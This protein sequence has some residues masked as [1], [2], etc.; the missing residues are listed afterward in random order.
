MVRYRPNPLGRGGF[1]AYSSLLVGH[2]E[3]DSL[4]VPISASTFQRNPF[5]RRWVQRPVVGGQPRTL[6]LGGYPLVPL[7]E[8]R[9]KAFANRRLARSGGDPLAEKKKSKAIPTF[10][11]A[12][13]RTI[14][15][16]R[17]DWKNARREA[18]WWH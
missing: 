7:A 4:P 6:G 17:A 3:R 12:A 13:A 18:Q 16:H 11:D 8:A 1:G 10:Q 5:A 2:D 14:A 9:D 15:V